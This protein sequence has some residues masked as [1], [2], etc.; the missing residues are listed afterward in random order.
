MVDCCYH[1]VKITSGYY[2]GQDG[3]IVDC[4]DVYCF[5]LIHYVGY[6]LFPVDRITDYIDA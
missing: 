5:V 3:I 1:R 4:N 6:V 2:S